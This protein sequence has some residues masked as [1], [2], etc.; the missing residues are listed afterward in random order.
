MSVQTVLLCGV[1]GQGTILAADILAKVAA[2]HK[3]D[4]KLS[5]VHGMAQRGGSVTTIVRFGDKVHAPVTDTGCADALVSFEMLEGLRSAHYL[6]S[7]G[8]IFVND[9]TI[10]P[11]SVKIGAVKVEGD[12]RALLSEY[13][14]RFVPARTLAC[15]LGSPRSTNIVLLGALSTVLPFSVEEWTDVIRERVPA[16]TVNANLAAFEA[17]R[18]SALVGPDRMDEV[19]SGPLCTFHIDV[20]A[21]DR[22]L[23]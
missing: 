10:N 4:V 3:F 12:T 7:S 5:E 19:F 23:L 11:L 22:D 13:S 1:G 21:E 8:T 20:S 18:T 16:A 9:E 17:G 14:T 6:K 15:D 2:A